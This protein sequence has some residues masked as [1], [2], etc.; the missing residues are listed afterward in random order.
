[1]KKKD[2]L[3]EDDV[4]E[5]G[6]EEGGEG[7]GGDED[8]DWDEDE[9]EESKKAE[10]EEN[11][12]KKAEEESFMIG[13]PWFVTRSLKSPPTQLR[14]RRLII[15]RGISSRASPTIFTTPAPLKAPS[16]TAG[17]EPVPG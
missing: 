17:E 16:P 3:S 9:D 15:S 1:M 11:M 12:D 2:S 7:E 8:G 5:E 6:H 4:E 13:N 10:E 14:G